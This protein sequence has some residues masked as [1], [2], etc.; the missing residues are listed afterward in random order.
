MNYSIKIVSR[1]TGLTPHVI[2]VWEKRYKAVQP[3]RTDTNRRLYS[4]EEITRLNLLRHLTQAGHNIGSI[5]TLE[6][7]ELSTLLHQQQEHTSQGTK[8]PAPPSATP[9]AENF[10]ASGI[11]S[12]RALNATTLEKTLSEALLSLGHQ[13]LLRN[14]IS[15]LTQKVGEL[16]MEGDLTAAHEHFATALIRVFLS[17]AIKPFAVSGNAPV[18]IVSTPAGQ[19][20]ELGV[21]LRA[22][23]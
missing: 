1:R 12:I 13:G 4:E 17:H 14:V 3:E 15:P 19:L 8:A 23:Q 5:A 7:G 18:I 22:G 9:T 16:W 2:R 11:A 21:E 6:A 10:L 20:H